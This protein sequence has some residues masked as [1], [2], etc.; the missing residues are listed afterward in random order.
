[1][2]P[3]CQHL[4]ALWGTYTQL[5]V[6]SGIIERATALTWQLELKAYDA[7]QLASTIV[8]AGMV[9]ILGILIENAVKVVL[10]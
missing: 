9:V 2:L 4:L 10:I 1:M 3:V 7:I 6:S 8:W 5:P